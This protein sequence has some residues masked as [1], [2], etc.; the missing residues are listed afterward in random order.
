M[1]AWRRG[2]REMDLILGGFVDAQLAQLTGS[3]ILALERL[4]A[5]NDDDLY[6]WISGAQS[7]PEEHSGAI[8]RL[9]AHNG[10]LLRSFVD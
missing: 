7:C 5:E 6:L 4:M 8:S 10:V 3:E 2:T 1:R 9:R